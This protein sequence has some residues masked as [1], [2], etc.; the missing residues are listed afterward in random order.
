MRVC[1][2]MHDETLSGSARNTGTGVTR[3]V[4]LKDGAERAAINAFSG[5]PERSVTEI[6]PEITSGEE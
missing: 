2:I 6:L 3:Y 1:G 5:A 4:N